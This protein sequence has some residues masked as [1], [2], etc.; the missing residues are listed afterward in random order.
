MAEKRK[1]EITMIK[2]KTTKIRYERTGGNCAVCRC[3]HKEIITAMIWDR[4]FTYQNI[5]QEFPDEQL[6]I[7][8]LSYHKSHCSIDPEDYIEVTDN[9]F[10]DMLRDYAATLLKRAFEGKIIRFTDVKLIATAVTAVTKRADL[11]DSAS[12]QKAL[13]KI[14]ENAAKELNSQTDK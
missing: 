3:D 10:L 6:T 11:T 8:N 14:L 4:A 12:Q 13:F 1:G 2:G 9:E 5:L 7:R